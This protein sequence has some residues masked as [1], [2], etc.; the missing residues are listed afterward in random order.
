[1]GG[2]KV[3]R[4]PAQSIG[5]HLICIEGSGAMG[6][7]RHEETKA[8]CRMGPEA[9]RALLYATTGGAMLAAVYDPDD[10]LV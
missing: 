6:P 8:I 10:L 9:A 1:M 2:G 3:S 4:P 7:A 5:G